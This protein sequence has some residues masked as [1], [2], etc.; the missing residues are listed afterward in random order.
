MHFRRTT[1]GP[2]P[3][4]ITFT[5][6][7]KEKEFEKSIENYGLIEVI[8]NDNDSFK[9]PVFGITKIKEDTYKLEVSSPHF[10]LEEY[11]KDED[12][13][14]LFNESKEMTINITLNDKTFV[15]KKC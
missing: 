6:T 11:Y 4:L 8:Y 13:Y 12:I 1:E 9:S 15:F 2:G 14:T 10:L 5:I 3:D 7:S